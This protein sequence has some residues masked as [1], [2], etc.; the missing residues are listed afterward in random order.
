[1][2]KEEVHLVAM[3]SKYRNCACFWC[4]AVPTGLYNVCL[5]MLDMRCLW[6]VLDLDETLIVGNTMRSFKD[7][8]GSLQKR[9]T[10]ETDPVRKSEIYSEM[11]LYEE[12][13]RL[14]KQYID[15][16]SVVENG[17][18]Y[19]VQAEVVTKCGSQNRIVRPV[20]RL[21]DRSIVLTRIIPKV[22]LDT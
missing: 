9:I 2:G 1:M 8:I 5:R 15:R 18:V 6:I 12:D 21:L 16:D 14:L 22:R 11:I 10:R 19:N 3:V 7:K 20:I 13:Q 4:Y 17:K